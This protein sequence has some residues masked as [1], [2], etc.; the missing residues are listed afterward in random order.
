[1]RYILFFTILLFQIITVVNTYAEEVS[2]RFEQLSVEHGLSQISV[3]ELLHDDDGY[4]WIATTDGLNRFDGYEFKV[5]RHDP[6][7]KNSL[8][9][10]HAISLFS[11]SKGY[12]W[13][14]TNGGGL[15]RYD[16][17]SESFIS[18]QHGKVD[19][20]SLSH[21][22]VNDIVEDKYGNI[23]VAT[24]EGLNQFNL[25]KQVFTR[26]FHNN[27]DVNSLSNNSI[28]VV[29]YDSK[30]TLWIGTKNGLNRYNAKTKKFTRIASPSNSTLNIT[31]IAETSEQE[32]WVGSETGLMNYNL[33]SGENSN[34]LNQINVAGELKSVFITDL[35][36]KNKDDLWIGTKNG[37][38]Q[39]KISSKKV[40]R[41]RNDANNPQPLNQNEITAL[42]ISANGNLWVGSYTHGFSR[43]DLLRTKFNHVKT[44][45]ENSGFQGGIV[46]GFIELANNELLIGTYFSGINKYSP[47]TN[48][49]SYLRQNP[50]NINSL[51]S[52]AI[53]SMIED[54]DHNIWIGTLEGGLNRYDI[55]EEN[56][57]HFK[58]SPN[59]NK[60]IS[61]NS[62]L[63][64]IAGEK[65]TLWVGT[66]GGGLNHFDM[67]TEVF[68]R[69]QYNPD[70]INSLSSDIIWDLHKDNNGTLWIGTES[71][72]L[73]KLDIKTGVFNHYL[74]DPN[75]ETSISNNTVYSIYQ[76]ESQVIWLGTGGGLN[77]FDPVAEVFTHYRVKDGLAN[78]HVNG[79]LPD[80]NGNLWISTNKGLS[81]FDPK[82]EIFKNYDVNDGLQGNEFNAISYYKSQD[83]QL[84]FGG[85]N[86]FNHFY[87]K[88]IKDDTSLPS[89]VLTDF[90]LLNKPVDIE[91]DIIGNSSR[92]ENTTSSKIDVKTFTLSKAINQLEQLTLSHKE[93]LISF[94]FSAL[95]FSEPMNNQ[96]AYMLEG[97]DDD[98][99]ETDAK[100]RR[101]TYTH[102][103]AG[104]YIFKVKASN[105]DGYWNEQGKTLKVT[106][107]P[108]PWLTWWAFTLYAL[109]ILSV[110]G[111]I[112]R[113]EYKKR[114]K[115]HEVNIELKKVDK[116]KDEFLAN[117]SHELRTP[118]NG[119]IGLAE[120]LIDGIAG[121]LP[122]KATHDLSMVV[123]SGYRLSNLVND[124]LDF[125][126]LKNHSLTINMTPI[127]LHSMVEVVL[128]LSKATI[129]DKTLVLI[130][131]IAKDLPV[132][133]ADEDRLQQI[134]F[135]LIGNAIKF[136][137]QGSVTVSAKLTNGVVNLA[138]TDTGIGISKQDMAHVFESFEQAA[139]HQTRMESGTGLGLAITKQLVELHGGIIELVSSVGK[140]STFSFTLAL[141]EKCEDLPD[142]EGE[143]LS[144]IDYQK[145]LTSIQPLDD[146]VD[147]F[148]DSHA[149]LN[150]KEESNHNE[151]PYRI[152]IVD[153]DAINRQVLANHLA[154]KHYLLEE[155]IGGQQALDIIAKASEG[156]PE[157]QRPFDLILLDIMMPKVSGYQVCKVVREKYLENELPIIFLTAKNQVVD[158]VESFGAGGNDYL[159]KPIVKHELLSRVETHLKLL[160]ISRSLEHQV[161]ERTIELEH[162]MQAKGEF[163]AKMSHEIRTPMNAIIGLGYLTLKTD[164]DQKQKDLVVKT[165]D[166][167]QSLLALINDILDFS[168]IEAGK[169]TIESVPMNI[170]A[171]IKKTNDICAHRTHAKGLE[172]VVKVHNNVPAQIESDPIRLQQILV[173]L[174]SNAIKFTQSGD[175]L[176]EV[177]V[178]DNAAK[179]PI[180]GNHQSKEQSQ[181]QSQ[182]DDKQQLMLEF[183][184]TDTGIGL[185]KDSIAHLFQ[186]FTQADN[187][188]TRKFGGTG[189]GLS[190]CQELTGLMGGDIW[191][192]SALGKGSK[193]SFTID[194]FEVEGNQLADFSQLD[195]IKN[196]RVLA[197]DDNKLCLNVLTELLQELQCQVTST[198]HA[199]EA[200]TL[201]AH[202]K[203]NQQP[204]DLVITDWRMP[205]MDGIEFAK[206]IQ[207]NKQLYDVDAVLMVTA[208]DKNDAESL[209]QSAGINYFLEKPINAPL[210]VESIIA[211]LAI[212]LEE[213]KYQIKDDQL[214][215][216]SDV[217][218]LLV[219]DNKLNQQ[220]V[221][222]FLE[223]SHANITIADNGLVALEKL[224]SQHF[225]L[226]L[227][228]IQMPEMDGITATLEIR[229]Q[230]KF[231]NLAIIAMTAH[232]MSNELERCIEVGM[233]DYFTKP[234]DPNVLFSLIAKWLHK[235]IATNKETVVSPQCND[236]KGG[237]LLI[238]QIIALN[239]LDTEK[240]LKA[241]GGRSHIYQ[242]LVID[243]YHSSGEMVES[244]ESQLANED[245]DV[246]YRT[247]H[248]LKSNTAYI[249][250]YELSKIAEKFELAIKTQSS[251][252]ALLS[253]T[254]CFELKALLTNLSQL[255]LAETS[256]CD[257]QQNKIDS[258]KLKDLLVQ[259]ADLLGQEDAK[260]ED[261]IPQLAQITANSEYRILGD[262]IIELIE[263]VEYVEALSHINKL[264]VTLA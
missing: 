208:F 79:I 45:N 58:K 224:A 92:S 22:V 248:S 210:L 16:A 17:K 175:I 207:N 173:N 105:G 162:A 106:V 215:D 153:D 257:V 18:F 6:E 169:M 42:E 109:L 171:L 228:D 51:A 163:L 82:T 131:D 97:F 113:S 107:L 260:V 2:F 59:D 9:N 158:L 201:L 185:N 195:A 99:I 161:A 147:Y 230:D 239:C 25:K 50:E 110:F 186:S 5:F 115:E 46:T 121:P 89:V 243:F 3:E 65:D 145:R 100:N 26:Y 155:A 253:E 14:G 81:K 134:L 128:A 205:N 60:S 209:A 152:L 71:G 259:M 74:N 188:I 30:S 176:I 238:E 250:A 164:L 70:D 85:L 262:N 234:I 104:D 12:L 78:D 135:N 229:K 254:L 52:N 189:L 76:D 165:Q 142:E 10:N 192:E 197:V 136:T 227:M 77:K 111:V 8:S 246:L 33:N 112:I 61:H 83:G 160:D 148:S 249:G 252:M 212:T 86:G 36:S 44:L 13:V 220:V 23:W 39:F 38:Y 4:L 213:N 66:W 53:S 184:V 40:K 37:G 91:Q 196:L 21:N 34:V 119:I 255:A 236:V 167:S 141:A 263:D 88:D 57:T 117:T 174:V 256:N 237:Q 168:K 129:G 183:S 126:K 179:L 202:A 216:F 31:S 118:L 178:S 143:M 73:N 157:G 240:A 94:E 55:K 166:A 199:K 48:Q 137:P 156:L 241:M 180:N 122:D 62:V 54:K 69:Y 144:L 146:T 203:K 251:S 72:G 130:N 90:L 261:L 214:F 96:Y 49:Y 133:A 194:C 187:S 149:Y 245:F 138:I 170:S 108:A 177:K 93:K 1:M 32:L 150:D 80:E 87:P 193:F 27:V 127:D 219:E 101:A 233:N 123:A 222:G 264:T 56:F 124:I 24:N 221:L 198:H 181:A 28:N 68:T 242:N 35:L 125:S 116:L 200:L 120:S 140:G 247:I 98:W 63:Q 204:F 191:V 19:D 172:L 7:H 75:L 231:K 11:D 218:I 244:I 232:A 103:P 95:H 132:V 114:L 67:K 139:S 84:F 235:G 206:A 64:I 102:I 43:F 20:S 190:I 154:K 29:F 159:T 211:T 15:N 41:F 47:S 182:T 151:Q 217:D 225:D 223:E 226:V 258:Q